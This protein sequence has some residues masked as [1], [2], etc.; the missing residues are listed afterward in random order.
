VDVKTDG[1]SFSAG[2]PKALFQVPT[3]N[4]FLLGGFTFVVTRDGQRFL[5]L[6]AVQQTAN[7]A[8]DVLVNWR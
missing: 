4:S 5:I 6:E 1:P 8:L 3:V 7:P 2:I